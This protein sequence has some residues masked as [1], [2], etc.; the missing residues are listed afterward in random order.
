MGGTGVRTGVARSDRRLGAAVAAAVVVTLAI[1]LANARSYP[2]V[3][4]YD[5]AENI[6]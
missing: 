5:A 2:P 1:G 3:G 6:A 4:G